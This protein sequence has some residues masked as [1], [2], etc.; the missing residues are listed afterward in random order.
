MMTIELIKKKA[1]QEEIGFALVL[2]EYVH[3]VILD[4]VFRKELFSNLVFQGGTALRLAYQGVRYSED[5]DFVLNK[6]NKWFWNKLFQEF[7]PVVSRLKNFMPFIHEARLKLQK[8][9][10]TF[11][12]FHLIIDADGLA[13][14]DRTNIEIANIPAY[15]HQVK[16]L[17][18]PDLALSPALVVEKPEEIF[19]DKVVAVFARDYIKG[20]DL[21]DLH[22]LIN[23][24][25]LTLTPEIVKM[26][27]KKIRD[28]GHEV[29]KFTREMSSRFVVL[30]KEGPEILKTEMDLFLPSAYRRIYSA[31]YAEICRE[32]L[33]VFKKIYRELKND[34]R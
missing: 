21:W 19:S 15:T 28:Y 26:A 34:D 22:Y 32:E 8:Q 9:S 13:S 30:E 5:L 4:Y 2:K 6:K 12:R 7:K 10:E 33:D 18:Y 29:N 16:I 3:L 11:Q 20:R 27:K 1:A 17:R 23:T 25:K 24:L 14:K 31:G